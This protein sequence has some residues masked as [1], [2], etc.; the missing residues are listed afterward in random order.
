MCV[1]DFD[2]NS[3]KS[4]NSSIIAS[5]HN[6]FYS[7]CLLDRQV[8]AASNQSLS[9]LKFQNLFLYFQPETQT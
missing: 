5:F 4:L 6:I 7:S 2:T 8:K 9:L 1:T 3:Q